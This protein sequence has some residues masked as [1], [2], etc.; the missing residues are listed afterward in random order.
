M[1]TFIKGSANLFVSSG[2]FSLIQVSA[3]VRFSSAAFPTPDILVLLVKA[4][5]AQPLMTIDPDN[6][7]LLL[8]KWRDGD[9]GAL[10]QLTPLVYDELHRLAHQHMRREGAELLL[11]Y[12]D[13]VAGSPQSNRTI[14][15]VSSW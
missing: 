3:G 9:N 2:S 14:P 12:P 10:E 5:S 13:T 8:R 15:W 11:R 6:V 1:R 7:T 4:H